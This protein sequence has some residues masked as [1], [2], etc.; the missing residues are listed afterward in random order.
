MGRPKKVVGGAKSAPSSIKTELPTLTT[1]KVE[2]AKKEVVS[3]KVKIKINYPEDYKAKK[4]YKQGQ[5]LYTSKGM[6][7]LLIS[8][9]IGKKVK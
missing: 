5:I 4:Y 1:I 6:G 8:T 2:K 3:E 9:G 7:D